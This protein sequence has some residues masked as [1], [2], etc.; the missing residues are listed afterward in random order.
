MEAASFECLS[1]ATRAR[2]V[3]PELFLEQ[4]VAVYDADAAFDI[5]FRGETTSAL[6]HWFESKNLR[7]FGRA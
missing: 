5:G 2:I 3:S 4:L 6:T 7:K 1:T